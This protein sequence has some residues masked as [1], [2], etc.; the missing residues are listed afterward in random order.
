LQASVAALD[1][2]K[3]SALSDFAEQ[4]YERDIEV[5]KARDLFG[6]NIPESVQQAIAILNT[7]Y[8][9]SIAFDKS[10]L[11]AVTGMLQ[12]APARG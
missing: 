5:G 8:Q 9:D 11:V 7:T 10:L 3:F 1:P 2:S 4:L 6:T 12:A